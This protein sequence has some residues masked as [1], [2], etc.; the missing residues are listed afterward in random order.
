MCI[1][2]YINTR[3]RYSPNSHKS[4]Y[5]EYTQN[6]P[7]VYPSGWVLDGRSQSRVEP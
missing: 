5:Q 4:V 1:F 3:I 7:Q 2:N 6:E